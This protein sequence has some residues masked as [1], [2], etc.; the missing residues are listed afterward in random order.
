MANVFI[1]TSRREVAMALRPPLTAAG[2]IV[3]ET[4]LAS[5][6]HRLHPG[7]DAAVIDVDQWSAGLD[8]IMDCRRLLPT[9][10]VIALY[11]TGDDLDQLLGLGAHWPVCSDHQLMARNVVEAV[12]ALC[13]K[14]PALVGSER[15]RI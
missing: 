3:G 13:Q 11:H 12:A 8:A 15:S 7:I 2:H 1:A 9:T 10:K 5:F 4:P 6:R 14:P